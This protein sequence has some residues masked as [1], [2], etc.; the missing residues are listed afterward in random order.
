MGRPR[1]ERASPGTIR[2]PSPTSPCRTDCSR[3]CVRPSPSTRACP[4]GSRQHGRLSD[5]HPGERTASDP[6]GPQP[7]SA[8]RR[9]AAAGLI[10]LPDAS[11]LE[12]LVQAIDHEGLSNEPTR[13]AHADR[14]LAECLGEESGQ[15]AVAERQVGHIDD[16]V[17][18]TPLDSWHQGGQVGSHRQV[19]LSN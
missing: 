3:G 7:H 1:A 8:A 9:R 11:S 5:A 13:S 2:A 17:N 6:L 4:N 10:D 12:A 14:T 15:R 16:A 18:A 19:D